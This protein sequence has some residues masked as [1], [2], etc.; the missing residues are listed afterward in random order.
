MYNIFESASQ[1]L[2]LTTEAKEVIEQKHITSNVQKYIIGKVI[3]FTKEV[4]EDELMAIEY[5]EMLYERVMEDRR[6]AEKDRCLMDIFD[7]MEEDL[8]YSRQ[9]FCDR[10]SWALGIFEVDLLRRVPPL[11]V[12][13]KYN[14]EIGRIHYLRNHYILQ[15]DIDF[16]TEDD[17]LLRPTEIKE[18]LDMYVVGQEDAK[19][20]ISS[21]VYR[22]M[23]RIRH[24]ELK[25][26][27]NVV[28]LIGPSGCGKTEIMRV[29][30]DMT[31]L[32]MVF[33]DVSS[34]GASQ[35][36]GRHKEDILLSLLQ[37]AGRKQGSAE[38]GIIF[39]D[40][41]DKLLL[42]AM[43]EKGINMHDD[44]QSQLLTMLE[45]SDVELKSGEKTFTMNT[46]NIL[47]VLAGAFQG[48]D[49]YIK[50]EKMER[51]D[52]TGSIGFCGTPD[53]EMDL[54]LVRANINHDVLM[55]YGMKRELAG[56]ISSIAVM[57][58]LDKE[59]LI[60]IMTEPK[61]NLLQRYAKEIQLSSGATLEVTKE[62]MEQIAEEVLQEKV[63]ARALFSI[64]RT[65]L[66]D[67]IYEAPSL[68]NVSRIL[69]TGE[70]V[71]ER[72]KPQYLFDA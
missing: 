31:N 54:S 70:T 39:M 15:I 64:L 26:T 67:C 22:H 34:L 53:K 7:K 35:Y 60:R 56:R 33:T 45:G 66:R 18:R 72:Q 59:M 58:K 36:R 14:K 50:K 28:L 4:T 38:K 46:S 21:A 25:M 42:P 16:P 51:N 68:K 65:V 55:K 61:D 71:R 30:R 41:F 24:P 63:G 27:N 9:A 29:I 10:V 40:E 44:V 47:F 1:P 6:I 3:S 32:P 13:S 12:E 62:A 48:I 20:V 43:S 57:E 49:E 17:V 19:K 52:Y 37:E 8:L 2:I 11:S 23:K 5:I 69:V